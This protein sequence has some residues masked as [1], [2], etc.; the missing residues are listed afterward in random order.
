MGVPMSPFDPLGGLGPIPQS[1]QGRVRFL[2]EADRSVIG[3]I[4]LGILFVMAFW[5][6]SSRTAFAHLKTVLSE[7]DPDGRLEVVVVDTDGCPDL[8]E[9]PEF[10]GKLHGN[11][12]AAW[13]DRGR[14]VAVATG[15]SAPD[16]AEVFTRRLLESATRP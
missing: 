2:A 5:S 3:T 9:N 15:G 4:R 6:G 1:H 13:I 16:A 8:Y 14:I 11:G 7:V 10:L 12:E